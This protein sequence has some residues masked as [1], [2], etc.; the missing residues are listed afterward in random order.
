[1]LSA[2]RQ[3]LSS[4][5]APRSRKGGPIRPLQHPRRGRDRIRCRP[6]GG[7]DGSVARR[8]ARRDPTRAAG[9]SRART[10]SRSAETGIR[11]PAPRRHAAAA[12]RSIDRAGPSRSRS[13]RSNRLRYPASGF[14][15]SLLRPASKPLDILE[16]NRPKR[17][18]VMLLYRL[19]SHQSQVAPPRDSILTKAKDLPHQT[20]GS[21]AR[22]RIPHPPG[23]DHSEPS[24]RS[25]LRPQTSLHEERTAL[26]APSAGSQRS[27]FRAPAQPLPRRQTHRADSTRIKG[28]SAC[29]RG[30]GE[31][32]EPCGPHACAA[33]R[34]SPF[35]GLVSTWMDEMS[36]ALC[37]MG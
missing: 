17:A 26:A 23:C 28:P 3:V 14:L 22:N 30:R 34:E 31:P 24:G 18:K 37:W 33:G 1:M 27:E 7:S 13:E 25:W 12:K 21:V 16:K 32:P 8:A 29:A 10:P 9:S 35:G 11:F 36:A 5:P 6:R 20:L 2:Q 4:E 19:T 15:R